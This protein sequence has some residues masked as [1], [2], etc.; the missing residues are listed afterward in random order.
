MQITFEDSSPKESPQQKFKTNFISR[1]IIK[2]GLTKNVQ[3]ANGVSVVLAIL[4][5]ALCLLSVQNF[6]TPEKIDS[7]HYFNPAT[8]KPDAR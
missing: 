8:A 3:I 4:L 1:L 7:K 5:I 6:L 2:A